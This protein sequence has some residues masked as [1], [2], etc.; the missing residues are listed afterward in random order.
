MTTIENDNYGIGR[1][2]ENRTLQST[3]QTSQ[4]ANDSMLSLMEQKKLRQESLDIR[5]NARFS[6]LESLVQRS[7]HFE[8]GPN[9]GPTA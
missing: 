9:F 4:R 2:V 7:T 1:P 6:S 5:K 3:M 8:S